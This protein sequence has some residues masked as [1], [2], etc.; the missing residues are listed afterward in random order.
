[1]STGKDDSGPAQGGGPKPLNERDL[2]GVID[3]GSPG[4]EAAEPRTFNGIGEDPGVVEDSADSAQAH[5]VHPDAGPS[6][7][8]SGYG[9][10]PPR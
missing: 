3:G 1:M 7:E 6:G 2:A 4:G 5:D 10:T 8:K 9:N